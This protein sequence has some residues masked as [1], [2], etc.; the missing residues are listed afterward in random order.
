MTKDVKVIVNKYPGRCAHCGKRVAPQEG[1]AYLTHM[2]W[3]VAH[4][5]CRPEYADLLR[6]K[7]EEK[8]EAEK[9]MELGLT[10]LGERLAIDPTPL[11][12]K[13]E[14]LAWSDETTWAYAYSG[15]GTL[16]EFR[17]Y[18]RTSP[19]SSYGKLRWSQGRGVVGIDPVKKLVYMKESVALCD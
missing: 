13:T 4:L 9:Q 3:A 16:E 12:V 10:A 1:M 18:L 5:D 17:K 7:A 11:D 2:G 8:Q 6:R 14:Q 15:D 19:E